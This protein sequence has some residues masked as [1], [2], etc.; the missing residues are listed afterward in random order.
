MIPYKTSK[1]YKRLKELLDEGK[2]VICILS[3]DERNPD[4]KSCSFAKKREISDKAGVYDFRI[5]KILGKASFED[6]CEKYN[7]EFIEPNL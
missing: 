6:W 5:V 3:T 1:D 2:E 7:I 4:C